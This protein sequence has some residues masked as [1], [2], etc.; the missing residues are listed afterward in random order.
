MRILCLFA[1]FSVGVALTPTSYL[2]SV[3]QNRFKSVFLSSS[4]SSDLVTIHYSLAGLGVLGATPINNARTCQNIKDSVDP[5]SLSTLYHVVSAASYLT[6]CKV[7]ISSGL[8]L[9]KDAINPASPIIDMFHAFFALKKSGNSVDE[10]AL[11]PALIESLKKDD[12]PASHG[13]AFLVAA[14]LGGNVAKLYDSIEDIVAQA[15]EVD[16]KYLQ[17][18]GGLYVTSLVVDGAYKLAEKLNKAPL[19]SEDKVV[20]FANYFLSRKHVHQVKTASQLLSVVKTLTTNPFHVPVAITR[21]SS[22]AVSPVTPNVQVRVTNLMGAVLEKPINVVADSARHMTDDAVV[23]SKKTFTPSASDRTLFELNFMQAKPTRGFYKIVVSATPSEADGRLLGLTGA[24]VQVKVTIQVSIENV[25]IGVADK[26][27]T[28]VA[29]TTKLQ[30]PNKAA[31]ALEADYHQKILMKFQLKDKSSG[32]LMTAH[33]AFVR[34][35]NLNTKQEIIFVTEA[36][37]TKINKFDLDIGS[38]AKDFGH[39]SGRYSMELIIGDAIIENPFSWHLADLVLT[40]PESTAPKKTVLDQYAPKPIIKH[41]FKAPEKRPAMVVSTIFTVLVAVPLLILF[42]LWARLGV[43]ISN[44]PMSISAVGFHVCLAG[45]F[46]FYFLYWHS[47]NMFQ[48]LRYVGLLSIPTFLF[49]NRLLSSI[50][51]QR[52]K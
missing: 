3:D 48:T 42:I 43:N 24:E 35:T 40:F 5:S 9:L 50:A 41:E 4:E 17:F 7:D 45:I 39:L 19:I 11:I 10:A 46:G 25:E 28:T 36:D 22:V 49:G 32:Q 12:L 44:F 6:D 27:Q 14:E 47:L 16:E 15:D 33:Q 37:N 26:D 52:K 23:L 34:L 38:G 2:T 51:A 18:E 1:L 20:K 31:N 29:R 8:D 30:H 21:A 13:Y